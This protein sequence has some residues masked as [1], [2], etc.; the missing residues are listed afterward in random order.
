MCMMEYHGDHGA[1]RVVE[2]TG[3]QF[4]EKVSTLIFYKNIIIYYFLY[5]NR[6][7]KGRQTF[8]SKFRNS[9]TQN[10]YIAKQFEFYFKVRRI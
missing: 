8:F 10:N 3:E 2:N 5:N 9:L 7:I 4:I 6:N 1:W